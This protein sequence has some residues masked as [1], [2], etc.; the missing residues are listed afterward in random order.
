MFPPDLLHKAAFTKDDIITTH[1]DGA[2][3]PETVGERERE[4]RTERE[5]DGAGG[6]ESGREGA[7]EMEGER[8]RQ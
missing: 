5:R 8:E 1:N 3:A 6:R 2:V 4:R 7:R